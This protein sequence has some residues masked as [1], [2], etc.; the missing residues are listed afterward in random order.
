MRTYDQIEKAVKSLGYKWFTAPMSLNY[1]WERTSFE[2]TNKFTDF[3][4]VCY[5]GNHGEKVIMTI[6]AT[7]K[8]GLKGSLLEPTTV[9][10]IKGTAVI[11]SPQQV[12][13]GWEF[14]DTIK[15]FSSYPYFRQVGKVNYWRD[16]NK[17]TII[18]KVQ[19]Q[20]AKIFGTHWHRMSQ[21]GTYGSGLVNNW[22]LGCMGSPEPEFEKILPITRVSCGIYGNKVTGTIIESK[23]II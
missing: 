19:R 23:H 10:G 1:V 11:E 2:A 4:H 20:I 6:P 3:L 18:D 12:E 21:N 7:T 14:R 9:E 16:G 8:P 17:D 15:E 5:Q 13:G 22:S